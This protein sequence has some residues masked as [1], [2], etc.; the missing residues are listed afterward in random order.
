MDWTLNIAFHYPH[1]R[2]LLGFEYIEKDEVFNYTTI[3]FY[4]FIATLTLDY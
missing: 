3:R 1:N 2:F 4:L